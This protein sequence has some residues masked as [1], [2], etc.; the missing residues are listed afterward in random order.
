MLTQR[1]PS[2]FRHFEVTKAFSDQTGITYRRASN[3]TSL[4]TFQC[5]VVNYLYTV[6]H[7]IV[8][9]G[10]YLKRKFYRE[11]LCPD[12]YLKSPNVVDER[13]TAV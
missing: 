1:E 5:L 6:Y 10:W 8:N 4:F 2:L 11:A 9:C 7:L 3:A 13:I 12:Y